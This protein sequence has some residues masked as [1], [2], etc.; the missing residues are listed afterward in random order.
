MT[1]YIPK[2]DDWKSL[3]MI[4]NN[5]TWLAI[6]PEA[7]VFLF[8]NHE[9]T[10]TYYFEKCT[11]IFFSYIENKEEIHIVPTNALTKRVAVA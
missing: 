8:K 7:E 11:R 6:K 9:H 1:T 2:F 10:E 4:N 5:V 3:G